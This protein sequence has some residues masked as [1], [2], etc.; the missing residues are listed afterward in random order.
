MARSKKGFSLPFIL[1]VAG[2]ALAFLEL[3]TLLFGGFRSKS[4]AWL[5]VRPEV[6]GPLCAA[7]FVFG[8]IFLII[9]IVR[10]VRSTNANEAKRRWRGRSDLRVR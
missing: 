2:Y 1:A 6:S 9:T 8:T 3:L 5:V 4:G 10:S 7:F